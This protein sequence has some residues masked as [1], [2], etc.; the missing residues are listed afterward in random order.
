MAGLPSAY[1]SFCTERPALRVSGE[2]V[3]IGSPGGR[4]PRVA[5]QTPVPLQTIWRVIIMDETALS[6]VRD[7]HRRLSTVRLGGYHD[8]HGDTIPVWAKIDHLI[9]LSTRLTVLFGTGAFPF[10]RPETDNSAETQGKGAVRAGVI[11]ARVV[12]AGLY[13]PSHPMYPGAS[14]KHLRQSTCG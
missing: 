13:R 4:S 7:I 1:I 6:L 2:N 10:F 8:V 11:V 5:T 9:F 14:R 12:F 3:L